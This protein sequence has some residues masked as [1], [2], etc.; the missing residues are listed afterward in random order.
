[1]F[2]KSLTISSRTEIIRHIQFSKGLN[3]IVDETPGYDDDDKTTGNNVGKTTVLA[4]IDFCLGGS[5]KSIYADPENPKEVYELVKEFLVNNEVLI[6]LILKEDLDVTDSP[7]VS[8]EKNFLTY[9]KKIQKVN[10]E[11]LTD[12]ELEL[13]LMELL[14]PEH[15][16]EK[17]TFRQIISHSI[18]YK[19]E[20]VNR[21]LRTLDKFAKDTEY[22]TLHLFLFNCNFNDGKSRQSILERIKVERTFETRLGQRQN[23]TDFQMHLAILESRIEELQKAKSLLNV[24][25]NFEADLAHL[26]QVRHTISRTSANISTLSIRRQLLEE[27]R[28]EVSSGKFLGS[29]DHLSNLYRQATKQ[30]SG[31]QKSFDDLVTFHNSMIDEKVAFLTKD[32]PELDEELRS[33]SLELSRLLASESELVGL[34]A[35][36]DS[37]SELESLIGALNSAYTKKGEYEVLIK[38]LD[39]VE[40]NLKEYE[41]QL[42]QIDDLLFSDEAKKTISLQLMKFNEYFS[43]VSRELYDEDYGVTYKVEI[44]KKTG[45]KVY[46]FSALNRNMSSGKKQGEISCFDLA[47][48]LFARG[49]EISCLDFLLNDKKELMDDHQLVK[50]ADFAIKNDIQ[51]VAS[52]LKDKLPPELNNEEYIAVKLSQT[53]KLFRI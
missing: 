14:I 34:I 10:Q 43:S 9:K 24:N 19:D 1:M 31:I 40:R 6:T 33:L 51:F 44:N 37:F 52:I 18:R 23:K 50:I 27:A 38:Q 3:L 5:A 2:L 46:K 29:L 28:D 12:D 48:I 26:N 45:H 25:V 20:S 42:S 13:R 4:L 32:L 21:T 17:P 7:E 53:D 35:K 15:T 11:P 16:S 47:Y 8:V 36:S 49:E 41:E 39:D 22:E 30:V